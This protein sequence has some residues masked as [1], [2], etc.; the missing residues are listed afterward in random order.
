M[1]LLCMSLPTY[2]LLETF[3]LAKKNP[4]KTPNSNQRL[5]QLSLFWRDME[6][7]NGTASYLEKEA[8]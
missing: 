4:P 1:I 6:N 8:S 2:V 3:C 5:I 7:S